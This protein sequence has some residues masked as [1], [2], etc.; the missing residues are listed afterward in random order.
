MAMF[1]RQRGT[2]N[3][4]DE[5]EWLLDVYRP[6]LLDFVSR[7]SAFLHRESQNKCVSHVYSKGL[8]VLCWL[9][10]P[11]AMPEE[12][13]LLLIPL[14]GLIQLMHVMVLYKTLGISP[15]DLVKR[16]KVAVGHCRGIGIAAAFSTLTDE[17][18]FYGVS[19]RIFGIHFLVGALLQIKFP[20]YKAL[21]TSTGDTKPCPMVS[22][23]GVIKPALEKL[24][25]KFNSRQ[26]SPT[27][28]AFLVVVNTVDQPIVASELSAAVKLVAFL[29]SESADPDKDQSCIPFPLRKPAIAVQYTTITAP[30]HCPLLEPA[31]DEAYAMTVERR[32]IF[33]V[34]DMQIAVRASDDGHDIRTEGDMTRYLFSAICMLPVDWPQTT[35]YPGITHIVD[36]G[37][38]GLSGFGLLAYKNIKGLG[39][40]VICA[41]ALVSRSSRLYLGSKADLY[42]T[43]LANVTT[44]PNWLTELGPKLVCTTNNGQLHIDTPTSHMLGVPMVMVAGMTPTVNKSF[45]A[46]INNAG[47]HA[48]LAGSGIFTKSDLER[49]IGN[50]VKLAKPG[51][52]ITLNCIYMNQRLWNFQF[53]ALLRFRAKGMP[54]AGLC[55]GSS[56]P[57]LDSTM[58][59]INSLHSAG[60]YH[61]A[62]KPSTAGAI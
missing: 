30:Y 11:Y 26:L 9:T 58:A 60:I 24:I 59:I 22:V 32:W 3:Y 47:Y 43:D 31:A 50:L 12:Q 1:G 8:D 62:F 41:G 14:V 7:M 36:F 20:C 6:L 56:V 55:I 5:A 18:S 61:V 10:T 40:P 52:G 54:I 34:S 53:P 13:Y 16:F 45:V 19:E 48:E 21:T 38:G 49:K 25:A 27:E 39:I 29:H 51:Q 4:L 35:Q 42:Q 23:Q 37:P 28:H 15:G 57:S 2:G 46:A 17:Q 33:H 44:A